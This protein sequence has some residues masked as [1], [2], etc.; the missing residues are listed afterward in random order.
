[1][2]LQVKRVNSG[3][4]VNRRQSRRN[5]TTGCF[6][7][8]ADPHLTPKAAARTAGIESKADFAIHRKQPFVSGKFRNICELSS[9]WFRPEIRAADHLENSN[10]RIVSLRNSYQKPD[11]T[12]ASA[13]TGA[14]TAP[15]QYFPRRSTILPRERFH[16]P[17]KHNRRWAR[18]CHQ[19]ER[20]P[21][22]SESLC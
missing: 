3:M 20:R 9:G 14:V 1:M 4:Y 7:S 17:L 2:R 13:D 15:K 18:Q 22:C 8:V 19:D 11:R 16:P 12:S 5:W 6:G 10:S 21:S